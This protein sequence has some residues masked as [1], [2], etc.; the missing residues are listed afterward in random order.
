M[1]SLFLSCS[2]SVLATGS[3]VVLISFTLLGQGGIYHVP[4]SFLPTVGKERHELSVLPSR[5]K[6]TVKL[7][8]LAA[9]G[10]EKAVA[11]RDITRGTDGRLGVCRCPGA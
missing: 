10:R 7:A 9:K 1:S 6:V 11:G 2:P 5:R 4:V 8:P 3:A